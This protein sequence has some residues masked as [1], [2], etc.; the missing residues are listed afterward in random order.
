MKCQTLFSV[1][2]KKKKTITNLSSAELAQIVVKVNIMIYLIF[3]FLYN[4][5]NVL[6]IRTPK[7]LI[8]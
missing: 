6:K 4:T 3:T 8:K 5:A 7:F 2:N 1:K